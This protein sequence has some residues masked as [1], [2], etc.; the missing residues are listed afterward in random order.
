[1]R[2]LKFNHMDN[3]LWR[4]ALPMIFSNISVPLLGV[5][6]TAVIGH[7]D[8]EVYLSGV[9]IGATITSFLFMLVLFLRMSTTGITAQAFGANNKTLMVNAFVQPLF[10]ALII[11]SLIT[12]CS[13]PLIKTALLI[14]GGSREVQIQAELFL[15]IRWLGAPAA[16]INFVLLG[17]LLGV[18]YVRA[19]VILLITGNIINIILD[20]LFVVVLEYGVAGA[21]SATVVSEYVTLVIGIF[22]VWRFLHR[23]GISLK[24][25][26]FS[27]FR[28]YGA[29]LSLNRDIMLRSLLLQ[30]C[31]ASV[32]VLGA[33]LDLVAVNAVLMHFLI[34][35][36]Y[37]LDGFAYAVEAA[38]G[39]AYGAKDKSRL[40]QV[41]YAACRQ[42]G[43]VACIFSLVYVFWGRDIIDLLTS[44]IVVKEAA[45]Q[46]LF[47]QVVL[48]LCG[49]WCY[50]LDGV[51][52][53]ATRGKDMRNS[54]FLA[55]FG[56]A[57]VL[58]L[59]FPMLGNHALWL[60]LTLFLILRGITLGWI[61]NYH[62][63]HN[64]WLKK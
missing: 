50:L 54:M 21:A 22:F 13:T 2:I 60:S 19:P 46:Y 6:D 42:A 16:L 51:F 38:S 31:F 26:R 64:S 28:N 24:G 39:E 32:T 29:L 8:N 1:M 23:R 12:I 7:L 5:V 47:W 55:A 61:W 62:L 37:A 44:L 56:Y 18:Q 14:V 25:S 58:W 45:Y 4:L 59:T 43:I 41:W 57:L 36:A 17:W 33:R 30:L 34:F 15:Q 20:I 27:L 63:K 48:P 10:L 11:G 9:A 52:I 53:G 3:I 49:I 35:T 40:M